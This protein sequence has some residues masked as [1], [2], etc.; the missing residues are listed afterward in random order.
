MC[1]LNQTVSSPCL[2]EGYVHTAAV[3]R[4]GRCVLGPALTPVPTL[5]SRPAEM[6]RPLQEESTHTPLK[7]S[8]KPC[9]HGSAH[10]SRPGLCSQEAW[11]ASEGHSSSMKGGS[12]GSP[13][14]PPLGLAWLT[15]G[16][17]FSRQQMKL[18]A[19]KLKDES[20]EEGGEKSAG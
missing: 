12:P 17:V 15:Q 8:A 13:A 19:E 11:A 18:T 14:V 9:S 6:L 4:L 16:P 5:C 1:A 3:G 2:A 10:V 20:R 7:L